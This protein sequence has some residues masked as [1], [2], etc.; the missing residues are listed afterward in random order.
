MQ[1]HSPDI[2]REPRAMTL[3]DLMV[4]TAGISCACALPPGIVW[5]PAVES[6]GIRPA[7]WVTSYSLWACFLGAVALAFVVV[8]RQVKYRR[9]TRP[10]EWLAIALGSL[11][12]VWALQQL[13]Q[14][15]GSL[16]RV[17]ARLERDMHGES[18]VLWHIVGTVAGFL[19]IG[20]YVCVLMRHERLAP[21]L[22][23][24]LGV[25]LFMLWYWGPCDV[26]EYEWE[27]MWVPGSTSRPR[28]TTIYS[29][30]LRFELA[31]LPTAAPLLVLAHW[32]V[33]S[34]CRSWRQ[35][36]SFPEVA[37]VSLFVGFCL[38]L[39]F[40]PAVQQQ[41]STPWF[42]PQL[43]GGVIFFNLVAS[44]FGWWLARCWT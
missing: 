24:L 35:G 25:S 30:A 14:S 34:R 1:G 27:R 5:L 17:I 38:L 28:I 16:T 3:L 13:H 31:C 33:W 19:V 41:L 15:Y 6:E 32:S 43:V 42:L 11:Y 9:A 10:A 36:W 29:S 44:L 8:V 39:Y 4:G 18:S 22:K 2:I 7:V 40:H 20:G 26:W 21:F 23:T 12:F 37:A